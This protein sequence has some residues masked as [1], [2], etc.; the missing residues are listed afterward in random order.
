MQD[1]TV[2]ILAGG[3]SK[4]FGAD[5]FTT[6]FHQKPLIAHMLEIARTISP[7]LLIVVSEEEQAT[8]IKPLVK[9]VRVVTDPDGSIKSALNGALTAFEYTS[10]QY[11]LLLPVDA[12]FT[13]PE[14]LKVLIRLSPGH[15][16][17]VPIWPSGYI[18]PIHS[19]YLAE[20]AYSKG[21]E[22][23]ESGQYRMSDLLKQIQ[24]VLYI[25]TE[26][27]KQ[28]DSE[29][30]TFTNLNTQRDLKMAEKRHRTH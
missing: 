8:K 29:L 26:T 11:T 21:L 6:T 12:P 25:S 23:I 7:E 19:V 27:L 1:V 28:F 22:I 30:E 9:N 24:H 5:K 13:Q 4:R 16:A 20:H 3:A 10:T 14:L 2:A 17:V 18:E 15:G